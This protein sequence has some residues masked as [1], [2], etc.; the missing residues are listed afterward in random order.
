MLDVES[1]VQQ[2]YPRFFVDRPL[3]ARPLVTALRLLFHE[4]EIRQ[5]EASYPHLQGFD[6]VE[7][8]LDY[9][10]FSCRLRDRERQYIPTR[11]R[12]VIA[13]NREPRHVGTSCFGKPRRWGRSSTRRASAV[14]CSW[15]TS[16]R[17]AACSHPRSRPKLRTNLN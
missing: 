8:V 2:R 12:V 6:F 3:L 9:F 7:Q 16:T 17:F 13:A 1:F 4:K 10:D 15:R 5:F 14:S 11:G